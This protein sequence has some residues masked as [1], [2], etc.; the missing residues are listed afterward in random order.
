MLCVSVCTSPSWQ[1]HSACHSTTKGNQQL[2]PSYPPRH[3]HQPSTLA[4]EKNQVH[5]PPACLCVCAVQCNSQPPAGAWSN[6]HK[7]A[8]L[9]PVRTTPQLCRRQLSTADA[10]PNTVS[11][12]LRKRSLAQ[13]RTR[14]TTQAPVN[15]PGCQRSNT[16]LLQPCVCCAGQSSANPP[17]P[18][19]KG[20]EKR[21]QSRAPSGS[22]DWRT[23]NSALH[24]R[25]HCC[26]QWRRPLLLVRLRL[27][28]LAW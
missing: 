2:S 16:L 9:L 12:T 24:L 11:P 14:H 1:L 25:L 3:T 28:C 27:L 19:P 26:W 13:P 4:K 21:G 7:Q 5:M 6:V 17:T 20:A 22:T 10:P 8:L 15:N 18:C 23:P